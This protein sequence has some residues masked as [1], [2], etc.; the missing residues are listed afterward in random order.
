MTSRADFHVFTPEGP[1]LAAISG[2]GDRGVGLM[3]SAL[4]QAWLRGV[5]AECM[6]PQLLLRTSSFMVLSRHWKFVGLWRKLFLR[7]HRLCL[8][9]LTLRLLETGA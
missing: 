8:Q 5:S 3:E 4:S 6:A 9:P 1:G 2:E 7:F